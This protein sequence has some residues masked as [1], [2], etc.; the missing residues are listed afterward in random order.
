VF[1]VPDGDG[2]ALPKLDIALADY[3]AR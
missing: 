1:D 2:P 3:F